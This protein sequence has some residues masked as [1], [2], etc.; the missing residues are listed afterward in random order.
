MFLEKTK[1]LLDKSGCVGAVFL[2]LKRA[3]DTVDH[4]VLLAKLTHF[5]FSAQAIMWMKSYL[6]NRK[7]C[8]VVGGVKS[9]Y[10]DCPVGVPQ[11]SIFGLILFS[12][13]IN[14]LPDVCKGVNVQLYADDAVIFTQAK[15]AEEAAQTLT[16]AM[17]HIQDWLTN[18]CLLLNTK[19]TV[20][21]I[22]SKHP[23]KITRSNVFLGGEEL[24]VV[25][26]FKY[27]GVMLDSALSFKSHVKMVSNTVKYNLYNF[28]QI[29]R[30]L[31]EGAAMMFL[32][33]MIF[34]HI[35]Y[36]LTSWSLAGATTLKPV[37]SLYK[38]SLK[39]LDKK[40][41]SYHHCNILSKYNLLSFENFKIF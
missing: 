14:D 7:Q 16:S 13:Y 4:R 34:S 32:H 35:D 9:P 3:F 17:A 27:L 41:F 31:T 11:G 30:S 26:E 29:R 5:V 21:M 6:S 20:C 38:K 19:K 15:N 37:E 25:N 8:V 28:K 22:F 39:V 2:D 33:T 1:C 10:L 40:H 36:C 24:M 23:T 12:L 18:S